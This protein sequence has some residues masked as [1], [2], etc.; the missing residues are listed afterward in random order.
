VIRAWVGR[1]AGQW[2]AWARPPDHDAYRHY[3]EAFVELLPPPPALM[4]AVGSGEGRVR[5]DL[6]ARG[7]AA[8]RLDAAP[9]LVGG[10]PSSI[11]TGAMW[12]V[13]RAARARRVG[14]VPDVPHAASQRTRAAP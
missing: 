7:Y 5:R 6:R 13:A 10:M 11:P 12:S 14:A 9:R 4:L 1:V 3:R 8:R 2:P